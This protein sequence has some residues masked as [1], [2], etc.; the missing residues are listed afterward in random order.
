MCGTPGPTGR[1]EKLTRNG[2]VVDPAGYVRDVPAV[3]GHHFAGVSD[4]CD[5]SDVRAVRGVH[6]GAEVSDAGAAAETRGA[7]SD[8]EAAERVQGVRSTEGSPPGA[9]VGEVHR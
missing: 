5:R 1:R 2:S 3:L 7:V 4:R 6:Q 8:V 9:G